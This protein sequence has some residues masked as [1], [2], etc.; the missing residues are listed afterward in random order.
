MYINKVSYRR[1]G[2]FFICEIHQYFSQIW[3]KRLKHE[4][5]ALM[6]AL[7]LSRFQRSCIIKLIGL[8]GG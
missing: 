5:Q 4:N 2:S 3:L 8:K 6:L 1:R 7:M